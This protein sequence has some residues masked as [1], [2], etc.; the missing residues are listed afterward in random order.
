MDIREKYKGVLHDD[1]IGKLRAAEEERRRN[2]PKS[3]LLAKQRGETLELNN[4]IVHEGRQLQHRHTAERGEAAQLSRPEVASVDEKRKEQVRDM[5][6]RHAEM[7][8][9][10][11][12]RHDRELRAVK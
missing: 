7:R 10:L 4:K 9:A 1:P 12:A 11:E 3:K 5:N 6:K 8:R 2:S